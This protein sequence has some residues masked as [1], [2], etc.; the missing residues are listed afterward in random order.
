MKNA[1]QKGFTLIELMIV[2]AII[3]ILAAV[4]L[5]AYQSYIATANSSKVNTHYEAA[6]DLVNAEMQRTRTLMTMQVETKQQASDR[7]DGWDATGWLNIF[8][9][10]IGTG[11]VASGSPEG[12]PAYGPL[13]VDLAG[14]VG[15][16]ITNSIMA[17][18][19]SIQISRPAYGDFSGSSNLNTVINW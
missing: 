14:T 11:K 1:M 8:E 18:P 17:P 15:I 3:G 4:A 19:F 16:E 13:P 2:V 6:A 7:L 5:P 10:E 9:Q 12:D